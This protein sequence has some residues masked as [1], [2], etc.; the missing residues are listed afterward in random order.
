MRKMYTDGDYLEKSQTWHVEDSAWKAQH[1]IK[2]I[3]QNSIDP[4][5][6]CEVGC[7]AGDIL[8]QLYQTLP[9]TIEYSGFEISPQAYD[10]CKIR[11]TDKIKYFMDDFCNVEKYYDIILL[12]DVI[13]HVENLFDFLRNIKRKAK[14]K[15]FHIPLE[16]FVFNIMKEKNLSKG[17]H[18]PGH[19]H[20]FT[21]EIALEILR[22]EGYE[23][24]DYFYTPGFETCQPTLLSKVMY[25][26]QK[27]V[28][29]LNSNLGIRIFGG[30][31]LL[32]LTK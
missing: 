5:T 29:R 14:Y 31:S 1:I 26:P 6:I 4:G 21:K 22:I 2:I 3:N 23:I 17:L 28:Y 27:I 19:I 20:F 32:I 10:L 30:S 11:E 13:E 24:I 25:V 12:I 16:M 9:S 18:H 7:G 8:Y 15:I